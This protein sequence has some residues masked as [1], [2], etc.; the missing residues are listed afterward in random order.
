M[1]K[2]YPVEQENVG[3][4]AQAKEQEK[5]N[6]GEPVIVEKL[7]IEVDIVALYGAPG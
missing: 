6:A 1:V 4:V 3:G 2:A 5:R 7:R